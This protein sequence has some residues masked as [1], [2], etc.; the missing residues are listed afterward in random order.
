MIRRPPRS[1]LFPYTTLFRSFES[2]LARSRHA[3]LVGS[4]IPALSVQYL[5]DADQAL[6]QGDDVVIGPAEDGRYLLVGL[7]R[8]GP[9]LFRRIPLG[10][11]EA[12]AETL[13]RI[14]ALG[15]RGI[16]LPALSD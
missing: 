6:A 2:A 9:A 10:G 7:S 11:S 1:T 3:I 16:E 14:G 8:C 15:R 5:R 12:L 13:R 4:D